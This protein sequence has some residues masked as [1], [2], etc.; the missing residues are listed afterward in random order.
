[1]LWPTRPRE[2]NKILDFNITFMSSVGMA[3]M[4]ASPDTS[5]TQLN[6]SE[7]K[8]W[9]ETKRV[10]A[11]VIQSE[12]QERSVFICTAIKIKKNRT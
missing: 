10:G 4:L 11:I 6:D 5:S 1:M 9:F 7:P 12:K 8:F 2:S 3:L